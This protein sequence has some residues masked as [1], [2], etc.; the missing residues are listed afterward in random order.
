M[1]EFKFRVWHKHNKV[2][3]WLKQIVWFPDREEHISAYP[4][5]KNKPAFTGAI[6]HIEMMQYTG[7]H[8]INGKEIYE[9]DILTHRIYS[10]MV[11]KDLLFFFT[12]ML[13]DVAR[14]NWHGD[15][16]M[17][18]FEVIG[19]IYENPELLKEM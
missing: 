3:M 1:K 11:V 15:G 6:T 16:E 14:W 17:L 18:G 10:K 7:F 5:D 19:N 9:G 2:M 4:F 12:F 8:D 13:P